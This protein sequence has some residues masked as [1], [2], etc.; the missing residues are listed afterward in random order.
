MK[1]STKIRRLTLNPAGKYE[2]ILFGLVT[3][4]PD[5][6]VSLALN[7]KLGTTLCSTTPLTIHDD[8]ETKLMFS[9]FSSSSGAAGMIC[10]LISNRSGKSWLIRKMKNIDY[11]FVIYDIIED[12]E[13]SNLLS[14]LRE[15]DCINAA[16]IIEP[17]IIKDKN[18]KYLFHQA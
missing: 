16:F 15:T 1:E 14:D 17:G 5:Y 12:A 9:K 2:W 10:D 6:R 11:F 18:M 4:E 8:N 13:I 3:A 7:K